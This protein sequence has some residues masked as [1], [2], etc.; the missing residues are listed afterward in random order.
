MQK[1][2]RVGDYFDN[3]DNGLWSWY[4]TNLR[5]G[6]FEELIG[7]QLKY[8]LLKRFLNSHF[9]GDNN[10]SI[11]PNK[12]ILLVSIPENVHEDISIL[13]IFLKDYFHLEKLEHI[14]ISKLTHSHC[15]NHENHY[16]LTDYLNNFQDPSF[17]EFASTSWQVQKNPKSSNNNN[18]N[19]HLIHASTASSSK[20]SNAQ[21]K[22]NTLD[23]QL[24]DTN[25]QNSMTART[26][27]NTKTLTYTDTA[28]SSLTPAE[29]NN[30]DDNNMP[31]N[32]ENENEN[33]EEDA[34]DDAASS[35]VL[36]FSH[37]RTLA[38]KANKVPK[39]FP[40]YTNEDY[41]PSHSEIVSIDSFA[42]EDV[43]STYPGQ[44]LS[45][46]TARRED[47]DDE[48]QNSNG[49][50]DESFE[51]T[52]SSVESSVSYT[53]CSSSSD[54]SIVRYHFSTGSRGSLG[55]GDVD[56]TNATYISE[57]SSITSS[58]E[59]VTNST[60]P[61]EEDHLVGDN[62]EAQDYLSGEEDEEE[63]DDDEDISSSDYSVLSILPSISI[64]DSLGYFRLVLQS[65][66]IQNPDTKEIFTAIRQSNN[67]PTVASVTDDWLLYDS[68]FSMNNL[69]IL[70]LQDLLDIKRSF[71]KILLY[72]MVIVTD[73]GP[74]QIEE[75]HKNLTQ[76]HND[77][78]VTKE[79]PLNSELSLS[80]D[81]QQYFPTTFDDDY[82]EYID[83]DDSGDDASLSE[84]SGPQMYLPTRMASNVTTAH[85]SIRTVNSIGEWAFNRHNSV[86][87]I[88]KSNSNE[89]DNLKEY[90]DKISAVDPY[91]MT[92]LSN[93]NTVTSNF[94]HLLKNKNSYKRNP[95]GNN[96]INSRNEL[97]KIKSSINAMSAVERSKSLPLPTLLKSLSGIDNHT[98]GNNK[99]RKRWK[100]KM[101]RFR[102]NK[103]NGSTDMDKSQ[104]CAIM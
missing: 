32:N 75:E 53:N 90:G 41:N 39:I 82:D 21:L 22:T 104:R 70:T 101:T 85:R 6:D 45:L 56:H 59:N 58:I 88:N 9:Y 54:S 92:Q 1:S 38:S 76:Q 91:P 100:F 97:K 77:V 72:T 60:T 50:D 61:E 19:R 12:K 62:Y 40:S 11:R 42:G 68:K 4:L 28:D 87:K 31:Q 98:N 63:V 74:Q 80:N 10:T 18:N 89:S 86:T 3:D 2:V 33:E 30:K 26:N 46:T 51:E 94:S 52:S 14:Q 102:N 103:S 96:E 20:P 67:E 13:E 84:Q 71:P 93:S 15:Y 44:D 78:D 99:D 57:L 65:I 24:L 66:L 7:N 81:P 49:S 16:L 83:D 37:P 5:L 64:C 36:N 35:I 29:C 8:T 69:Q 34:G 27:T 55:R 23:N 43:S 73:S 95:K 48:D 47:K 17:L 79:E 25:T